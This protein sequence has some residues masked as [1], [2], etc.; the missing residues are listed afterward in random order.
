MSVCIEIGISFFFKCYSLDFCILK[1]H[2][3]CTN[4]LIMTA[5][6]HSDGNNLQNNNNDNDE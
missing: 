6:F 2:L 5:M 1:P 3:Q 4:R